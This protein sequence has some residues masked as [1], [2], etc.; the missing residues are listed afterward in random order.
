LTEVRVIVLLPLAAIILL[1]AA[2]LGWQ[3]RQRHLDRWLGPYLLRARDRRP[4][5]R[6]EP[7]H[8]I[9]CIADHFEPRH[10]GVSLDA[11]RARLRRWVEDYPR[12]FGG[13][14]DSDGRPPRH[15][16]FYPIEQYDPEEIDA[17]AGLCREGYGE[18]EVHLHHDNDTADS[19]RRQLVTARDVLAGRHGLLG[20]RRESGQPAYG[21]VHGNWALANSHPQGRYCGVNDELAVLHE[22]GCYA[23][24]TLPSAPEPM[25][26]SKINSLYYATGAPGKS[27]GHET[28][29]DVGRGTPPDGALL[30]IQGPLVLDWRRRKWG[31]LPRIENGCLQARQPPNA[32][33]LD[34]WLRARVQVPVRPDWFFVK[35]HSHGAVERNQ[36]V[37]LAE[38]M[39]RFHHTLAERA[40]ADADFHFHYVTAREMYNLVRAAEAGWEGGVDAARDFEVLPP[41]GPQPGSPETAG[42]GRAR[43]LVPPLVGVREPAAQN[44]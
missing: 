37:V 8:L 2:L 9:V 44:S 19:L 6:G 31:I 5:R 24:F 42:A 43:Q 32:G 28:G 15:T 34:L 3:V 40:R 27:R 4:P 23:D 39:V 33:R 25:Q 17:L 21:F 30:I 22:T 20:R 11:A 35:L 13:F 41:I 10:G 12:L 29:T 1:G 14:R 7:V 18:V 26:T 36:Q 16:F 38:P